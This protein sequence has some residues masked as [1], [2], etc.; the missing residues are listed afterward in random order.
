MPMVSEAPTP[1]PEAVS[2]PS[3]APGF[4]VSEAGPGAQGWRLCR[5]GPAEG[6][7]PPPFIAPRPAP[8]TSRAGSEA[9]EGHPPLPTPGRDSGAG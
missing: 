6:P 9:C 5:T 1:V 2:E 4:E 8:R 7:L 3:G